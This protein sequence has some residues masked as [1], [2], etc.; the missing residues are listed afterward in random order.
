M[1]SIETPR[2]R[3]IRMHDTEPS[4]FHVRWLHQLWSDPVV[5][6]WRYASPFLFLL[7]R[8]PGTGCVEE[9]VL[10]TW[11]RAIVFSPKLSHKTLW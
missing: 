4:S 1:D 7:S 10:T 6:S 9:Q 8:G 5:Q 2:L 11:L 3:L